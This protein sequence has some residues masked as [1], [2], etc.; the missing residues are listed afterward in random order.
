MQ[1]KIDT[2]AVSSKLRSKGIDLESKRILVTNFLN[3]DQEKDLRV[4]PNCGGLGRI[5]HFS[6]TT[7][8]GWPLNPLPIEPACKALGTVPGEQLRAQVF[9]NAVCNWRCWYCYVPFGLLS[10]N[11][12]HSQWVTAE[13]LLDLHLRQANPPQVIDL[14]GGQPDLTP[15]WAPWML[16]E[17]RKRNLEKSIYVWSDD[18]LSTDFFWR[19]LS[20]SQIRL[21]VD[22]RN[23]GRVCCFKGF[24]EE[25]FSFNT[26]AAGHLFSHQF[27]LFQRF[28]ELGIDIYAYVTLTSPTA[29]HIT[30]RVIHFMDRL[31]Q[32]HPNLPL[33]TIPL[34]VQVF[35]PV[36]HRLNE[37]NERALY[38]QEVAVEV[39]NRQIEE[40]FSKSERNRTITE[41]SLRARVR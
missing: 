24:D 16:D 9:Q 5:R 11:R 2:G 40:R 23:Y 34:E 28:L 14:T 39:W 31:Q 13:E 33:R 36:H 37:A 32:L 6:R 7:S 12:R 38:N 15:E 1:N 26:C 4:P 29:E 35:T 27:E 17:I 21:M 20:D 10:A 19:Y 30:D 3:T 8:P 41:V 22:A 25:S 18:N